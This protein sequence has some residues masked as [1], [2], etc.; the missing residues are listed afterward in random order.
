MALDPLLLDLLEAARSG[1]VLVLTGAGISTE[2][3][4]PT[5]RGEEGYW[6]V[7]SRNYVP[8][9][10]ATA[11]MFRSHPEEVW[12][13]YLCRFGLCHTCQPNPAHQALVRLEHSLLDRFTLVTQNIDGLHRRAGSSPRRTFCIHGDSNLAR[14]SRDCGIGLIEQPVVDLHDATTTPPRP[15]RT[16]ISHGST[17][18]RVEAGCGRMFCGSTNATMKSSTVPRAHSTRPQL[19]ISCS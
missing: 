13:W 9:E 8:D 11:R 2:S 14:C 6:V 17:V 15:S 12:R 10:M 3:G 18:L 5:F 16:R 1:R 4:I 19:R 7:G